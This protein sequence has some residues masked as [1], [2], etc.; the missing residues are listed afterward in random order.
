VASCSKEG[1]ITYSC[2]VCQAEKY[3][4]IPKDEH[5][6]N[7]GMVTQEATC[8]Q[9]GVMVYSC[10]ACQANK[11]DSAPKTEHEFNQKIESLKY[12]KTRA[13]FA[14]GSIYYHSCVCGEKGTDTFTLD[15]RV[16]WIPTEELSR[17]HNLSTGTPYNKQ[18]E[19]TIYH[20]DGS[21]TVGVISANPVLNGDVQTGICNGY[22]IR[23]YY[24]SNGYGGGQYVFNYADLV[25]AGII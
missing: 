18:T 22:S 20:P 9:E 24:E 14:S 13:S 3:E 6:W 21:G 7:S 17:R 8:T 2:A 19:I 5:E 16:E 23:F 10:T 15:D 4:S 11:Y 25:A 1:T 12:L